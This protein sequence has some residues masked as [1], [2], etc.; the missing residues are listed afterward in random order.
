M[1]AALRAA[2]PEVSEEEILAETRNHRK[3][4]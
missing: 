1:V 4:R 3:G 2:S